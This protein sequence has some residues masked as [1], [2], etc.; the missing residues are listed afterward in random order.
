MNE[1]ES[2]SQKRISDLDKTNSKGHLNRYEME[3]DSIKEEEGRGDP[4]SGFNFK[5][6]RVSEGVFSESNREGIREEEAE[7]FAPKR[8]M[9]DEEDIQSR[10]SNIS[11]ILS[12]DTIKRIIIIILVL[13]VSIPI[14]DL[15][16]YV[17]ITTH[18]D[19]MVSF[20]LKVMY[21]LVDSARTTRSKWHRS[22]PS[23]TTRSPT[24]KS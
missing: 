24:T 13:M 23:S 3:C 20:T 9:D 10:E 12:D 4:K 21:F 22:T 19:F 2:E 7:L 5:S 18:W 1:L 8:E 11:R 17:T 6:I 14:M 16:N 15:N